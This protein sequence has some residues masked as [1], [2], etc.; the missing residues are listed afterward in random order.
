MC[1]NI[2]EGLSIPQRRLIFTQRSDRML[3][4]AAFILFLKKRIWI[5][6]YLHGKDSLYRR[7]F[8]P[9]HFFIFHRYG[10]RSPMSVVGRFFAIIVILSGLIIF[11]LVTSVM[12]TA[13]TTATM[14]TE[15]SLYGA[16]VQANTTCLSTYPT[17]ENYTKVIRGFSFLRSVIGPEAS[18]HPLNQ[19]E[20]KLKPMVPYS[21]QFSCTQGC[22]HKLTLSPLVFL[23][24]IPDGRCDNFT[25]DSLRGDCLESAQIS[26]MISACSIKNVH[27]L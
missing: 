5:V 13:I 18:H 2:V 17:L 10:D 12:T 7:N 4:N 27:L 19:S 8:T 22:W 1:N 23:T 16:K 21:P 3:H 15:S 20:V 25:R 6:A 11:G 24:F 26:T 14:E 9:C